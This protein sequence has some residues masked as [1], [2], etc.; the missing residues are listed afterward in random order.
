MRSYEGGDRCPDCGKVRYLTR[1]IARKVAKNLNRRRPG[2]LNAYRCGAFWH[3]G[4]LP[5]AVIAGDQTRDDLDTIPKRHMSEKNTPMR[6][7]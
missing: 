5:S 4:H 7:H 1:A 3:L 2:H 6:K